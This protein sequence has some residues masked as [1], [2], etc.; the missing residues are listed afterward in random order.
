MTIHAH[1]PD[2]HF[3]NLLRQ[4][5]VTSALEAEARA[6]YEALRATL[7][8]DDGRL[9]VAYGRWLAADQRRR[10]LIRELDAAD[11]GNWD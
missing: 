9:C 11:S 1:D 5:H 2:T 6:D 8:L 3:E 7:P 4:W 10:A